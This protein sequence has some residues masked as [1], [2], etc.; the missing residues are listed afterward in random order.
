MVAAGASLSAFWIMSA[1]SWMQ[2]PAGYCIVGQNIV[3]TNYWA[4]VFNPRARGF[5]HMWVCQHRVHH[6]PGGGHLCLEYPKKIKYRI[7][8]ESFQNNDNCRDSYNASS[9]NF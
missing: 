2:T 4:A 1:N 7:L 5:S 9:S 8:S 3:I 6:I